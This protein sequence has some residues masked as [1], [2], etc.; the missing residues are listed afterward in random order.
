MQ[1][2][3]FTPSDAELRQQYAL[4]GLDLIGISF[5]RAIAHASTLLTL[6]AGIQAHRQIAAIRSRKSAIPHQIKEAA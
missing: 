3:E 2:T 6:H 1:R 4:S 5:E